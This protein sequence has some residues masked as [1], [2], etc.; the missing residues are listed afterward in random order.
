MKKY[1]FIN[2]L[3]IINNVL[4]I[5]IFIIF[6]YCSFWFLQCWGLNLEPHT[7]YARALPTIYIP[8]PAYLLSACYACQQA[9]L[10]AMAMEWEKSLAFR[11]LV[12]S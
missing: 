4:I 1:S 7:C 3:I 2:S 9:L 11:E 5:H 8:V 10:Q 12:R 6:T